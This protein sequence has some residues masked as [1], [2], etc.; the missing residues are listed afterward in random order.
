MSSNSE[1][2][3]HTRSNDCVLKKQTLKLLQAELAPTPAGSHIRSLSVRAVRV[4]GFSAHAAL[5]V[6]QDKKLFLHRVTTHE[7][8]YLTAER[9][10]S[11]AQHK[12]ADEH[13]C[14]VDMT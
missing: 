6:L 10:Q 11:K 1:P 7:T 5:A 14:P 13:S 2:A 4:H 12:A 9:T 8:Y 3:Q